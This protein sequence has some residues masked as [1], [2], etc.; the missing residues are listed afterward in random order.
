MKTI[1]SCLL[2][3]EDPFSGCRFPECPSFV[4]IAAVD[5]IKPLHLVNLSSLVDDKNTIVKI[6]YSICDLIIISVSIAGLVNHVVD[7]M[8]NVIFL[9]KLICERE[10][11]EVLQPVP[12]NRINIKPNNE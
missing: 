10:A 4:L 11:G 2:D 12:V 7:V 8:V 1:T 6:K 9:T 5:L 3:I